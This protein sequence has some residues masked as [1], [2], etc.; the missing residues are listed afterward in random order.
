MGQTWYP[1]FI[2]EVF[3]GVANFSTGIMFNPFGWASQVKL[4]QNLKLLLADFLTL[5]QV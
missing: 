2:P 3:P 4:K 5:S 1:T